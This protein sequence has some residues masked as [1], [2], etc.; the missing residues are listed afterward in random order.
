MKMETREARTTQVPARPLDAPASAPE[1]DLSSADGGGT[2]PGVGSGDGRMPTRPGSPA[3]LGGTQ[4][5]G[6]K[7]RDGSDHLPPSC[8]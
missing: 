1:R 2:A 4:H 6:W 8:D 5:W 3:G 7:P